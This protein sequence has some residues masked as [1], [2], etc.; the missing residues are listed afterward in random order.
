MGTAEVAEFL[1]LS[2]G[3]VTQ[4]AQGEDFPT[5]IARLAAGPVWESADIERWARETGRID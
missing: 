1:G 4:L 5:P 2:R 3:R